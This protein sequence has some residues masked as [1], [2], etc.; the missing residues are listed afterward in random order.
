MLPASLVIAAE[1]RL[2]FG[3]ELLSESF[4]NATYSLVA[5]VCAVRGC[6][7][8]SGNA[9]L[10]LNAA[11]ES[12]LASLPHHLLPVMTR[13]IEEGLRSPED[14]LVAGEYEFLSLPLFQSG[15]ELPLA[16]TNAPAAGG[17]AA[18]ATGTTPSAPSSPSLRSSSRSP[19]SRSATTATAATT[20]TTATTATAAT[21]TTTATTATAATTTTTATATG[22]IDAS[23]ATGITSSATAPPLS[24]VSPAL[25]TFMSDPLENEWIHS[26]VYGVGE[27]SA[28]FCRAAGLAQMHRSAVF[29][30]Y[31]ARTPSSTR[32]I[33]AVAAAIFKHTG[34]LSRVCRAHV[35]EQVMYVLSAVTKL[36]R[37]LLEHP[38]R[39]AYVEQEDM[40]VVIA[41]RLQSRAELVLRFAPACNQA[42]LSPW[43]QHSSRRS[44]VLYSS[45]GVCGEAGLTEEPSEAMNAFARSYTGRRD[46]E[47]L[48]HS[49][50]HASVEWITSAVISFVQQEDVDTDRLLSCALPARQRLASL[51]VNAL[52]LV[53]VCRP[54]P[55]RCV[56]LLQL[57]TS[58]GPHYFTHVWGCSTALVPVLYKLLRLTFEQGIE[59]VAQ[60]KTPNIACSMLLTLCVNRWEVGV[61]VCVYKYFGVCVTYDRNGCFTVW[62]GSQCVCS[63]MRVCMY[64]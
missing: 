28:P 26:Y 11:M 12:Y 47:A 16:P 58:S 29:L 55:V 17:W 24:C 54:E 7:P 61:C 14:G 32:A 9:Y 31:A 51:Y 48:F 41:A 56:A 13:L 2:M 15:V 53:A 33:N 19:S 43:Q 36:K 57:L 34:L 21:T 40:Y 22:P 20:T 63:R 23:C 50:L 64:V 3:E 60:S 59:L 39:D 45:R 49:D 27:A 4:L 25:P 38:E 52:R 1:P 42:L 6:L 10:T 35:D 46:S 5:A 18:T 8:G 62:C 30:M 44:N 37:W